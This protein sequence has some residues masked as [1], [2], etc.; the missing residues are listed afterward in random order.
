MQMFNLGKIEIT[1]AATAVIKSTQR[2]P[3]A[4]LA[5]HQHGDWGAVDDGQRQANMLALQHRRQIDSIYKVDGQ[6]DL[7]VSTS[8]G[9]DCTQILLAIE[10]RSLDVSA[11]EGYALWASS[12]DG[13]HNPLIVVE[14][15]RVE[16]LLEPLSFTTVLDVGCGTGRHALQLARQ[17]VAVTAIDQSPHMLAVARQA[18]DRD[19]LSIDFQ[20]R[21]LEDGLPFEACQFDLLVC[22]LMLCH[23]PD[24]AGAIQEF[25]R[26]LQPGG[27]LL[28]TDFHPEVIHQGWRTFVDRPGMTYLLP[29]MAHRR[30][31]Y[32]DNVLTSG[33]TLLD[34]IDVPINACPEGVLPETAIQKHGDKPFCLI[35]LA[36]K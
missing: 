9:R 33:F 35:L 13:G 18:A 31:D 10:H 1:A 5:R 6:P 15:P 26:V 3:Q 32:L 16:A 24:L 4:Y 2:T 14:Q 30:A 23:V 7:L 11:V 12:Y 29:N 25:H 36:Q 27:H 21:S 28:I 20:C 8:A 34:V 19:E 22:A 17:G